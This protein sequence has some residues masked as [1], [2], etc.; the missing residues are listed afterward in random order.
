M[1][2]YQNTNHTKQLVLP[3]SIDFNE[4][5]LLLCVSGGRDSVYMYHN[6]IDLRSKFNFIIG[7]AHVNYKT[8]KIS[9]K[10]ECSESLDILLDIVELSELI[11]SSLSLNSL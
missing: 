7:L 8:S 5:K 2:P 11:C 9:D 10:S 3:N 6:I 4:K 1:K